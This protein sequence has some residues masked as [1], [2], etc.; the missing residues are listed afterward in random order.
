MRINDSKTIHS[1]IPHNQ[2]PTV[3]RDTKKPEIKI[4]KVELISTPEK[5]ITK[6]GYNRNSGISKIDV[7]RN[8]IDSGYYFSDDFNKIFVKSLINCQQFLTDIGIDEF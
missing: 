7:I 2:D 6:S 4:D 8:K 1:I 3:I 5:A